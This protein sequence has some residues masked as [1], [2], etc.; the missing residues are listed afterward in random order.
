MKR[1]DS[2]PFTTG[3]ANFAQPIRHFRFGSTEFTVKLDDATRASIPM[4]PGCWIEVPPTGGFP[5]GSLRGATD[6][7][8]F[9]L[10]HQ[11]KRNFRVATA[12]RQWTW[13]QGSWSLPKFARSDGTVVAGY[14]GIP[15]RLSSNADRE[16][17]L[18]AALSYCVVAP[19]PQ[20]LDPKTLGGP[21]RLG[22]LRSA[23]L[24]AGSAVEVGDLVF[25]VVVLIGGLIA[26]GELLINVL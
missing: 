14:R 26:A 8:E 25:K 18:I 23:G 22:L 9:S 5:S 2:S 6:L 15:L 19:A 20:S 17:A 24:A 13:H 16:E 21:K 12:A 1:S 7:G 11:R 10:S 3:N 4:F